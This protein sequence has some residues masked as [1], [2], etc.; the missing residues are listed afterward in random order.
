MNID[1]NQDREL[2]G[3]PPKNKY[4]PPRIFKLFLAGLLVFLFSSGIGKLLE[5]AVKQNTQLSA[6]TKIED[7][8]KYYDVQQAKDILQSLRAQADT[9]PQARLIYA[10]GCISAADIMPDSHIW[11]E[12]SLNQLEILKKEEI[13]DTALKTYI[14]LNYSSVLFNLGKDEE[15]LNAIK[16]VNKNKTLTEILS[17]APDEIAGGT[18]YYNLYAYIL[19][20]ATNQSIKNPELALKLI[21]RV[22]PLP[23]G[24][25]AA[26]LDTLA[27]AY[28]ANN[29][30]I[31][32]IKAQRIAL[33]KADYSSLW[34][35]TEHYSELIK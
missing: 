21:K 26:Y 24:R 3:L 4:I 10:S 35:L 13:T 9:S 15:A 23:D 34:E 22:I 6:L 2:L 17:I 33:A 11:L 31:D 29:M 1:I 7:I 18:N 5:Y 20:T 16:E 27:M 25:S 32:A 28:F 14:T 12:E 19:A 8:Y 30:T